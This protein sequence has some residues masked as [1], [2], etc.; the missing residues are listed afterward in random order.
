MSNPNWYDPDRDTSPFL[1]SLHAR[2]RSDAIDAIRSA[3]DDYAER[4]FGQREFFW[5]RPHKAG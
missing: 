3:I 4:E 5:D 2:G 1:T